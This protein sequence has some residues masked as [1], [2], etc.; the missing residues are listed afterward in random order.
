MRM[1]LSVL[2]YLSMQRMQ[3]RHA[4]PFS[5]QARFARWLLWTTCGP[6]LRPRWSCRSLNNQAY[7]RT[8]STQQGALASSAILV[9]RLLRPLAPHLAR[10]LFASPFS[11][12]PAAARASSERTIPSSSPRSSAKPRSRPIA[13]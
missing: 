9:R 12:P 11:S 2:R 1:W 10:R 7:A 6:Q 5:A 13:E 3:V 4:S 8:A